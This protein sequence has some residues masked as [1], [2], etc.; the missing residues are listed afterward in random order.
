MTDTIASDELIDA[1][2]LPEPEPGMLTDTPENMAAWLR[3]FGDAVAKDGAD[4]QRIE[5]IARRLSDKASMPAFWHNGMGQII[6]TEEKET[7]LNTV[8]TSRF[9]TPLYAS[10]PADEL[11]EALKFY[12]DPDTYVAIAFLGD[13]PC[14]EFADDFSDVADGSGYV[15][16]RPGKRARAAL[17]NTS[18]T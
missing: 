8:Q 12:A 11:R 14:G 18:S 13:P 2:K 6:T 7:G 3:A 9:D 10:P 15:T 1:H 17:Q 4:R 16:E 5:A